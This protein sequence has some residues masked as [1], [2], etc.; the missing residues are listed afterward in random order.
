[1]SITETDK[2]NY[3]MGFLIL[4]KFERNF[5]ESNKILIKNVANILEYNHYYVEHSVNEIPENKNLILDPPKFSNRALAEI[6]IRDS[7]RLTIKNDILNLHVIKWLLKFSEKND[8]SKE[9]F[10]LELENFLDNDKLDIDNS[11]EIQK[12]I[13]SRL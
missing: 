11:F 4:I 2:N 8:L 7:M 9:W 1:M 3:L 5:S 10:Y 12:H 13:K 6:F